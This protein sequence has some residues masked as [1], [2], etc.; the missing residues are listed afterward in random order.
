M[1][2]RPG[3]PKSAFPGYPETDDP[4]TQADFQF[5]ALLQRAQMAN[6]QLSLD[7]VAREILIRCRFWM[8]SSR[9]SWE[10]C[11]GRGVFVQ[12]PLLHDPAD[13][14]PHAEDGD[15]PCVGHPKCLSKPSW[16][17]CGTIR[18]AIS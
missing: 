8:F 18:T 13:H 5:E 7:H 16:P 6:D 2:T 14:R 15:C 12:V 3:P 9:E 1:G 17:G 4:R 10:K 11:R